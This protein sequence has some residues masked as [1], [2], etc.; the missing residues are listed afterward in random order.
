MG[1]IRSGDKKLVSSTNYFKIGKIIIS[2]R[3]CT[4]FL[5]NYACVT[6]INY[7]N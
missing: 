5:Q 6:V 1:N 4:V 2:N 7:T 3:T